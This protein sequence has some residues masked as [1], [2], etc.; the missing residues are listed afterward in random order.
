MIAVPVLAEDPHR[1]V[2]PASKRRRQKNSPLHWM[3]L[4]TEG[5]ADLDTARA[6]LPWRIER[7]FHALKVGTRIADRRLD[8]ADD[9]RKFL[10]FDAITVFR[11]WDR[12]LLARE[13]PDHPASRQ[14]TGDDIRAPRLPPSLQ[15]A[16][17]TAGDDHRG[18]RPS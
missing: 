15:G 10:A 1:P 18:H 6:V 13:R 14:V 12:S 7:F 16:P 11:V 2:L 4:T 9:L 8:E 5:Q 3:L 17:G